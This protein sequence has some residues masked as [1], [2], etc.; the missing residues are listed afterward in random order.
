MDLVHSMMKTAYCFMKD[1]S[2]MDIAREMESSM[3]GREMLYY[4]DYLIWVRN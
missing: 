4:K 2:K 3:I 1:T